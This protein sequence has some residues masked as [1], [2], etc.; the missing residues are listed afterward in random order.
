MIFIYLLMLLVFLAPVSAFADTDAVC[1]RVY[2]VVKGADTLYQRY[3]GNVDLST[4]NY[5]ITELHV[6]QHGTNENAEVYMNSMMSAVIDSGKNDTIAAIGP[7]FTRAYMQGM[8]FVN[9]R[10]EPVGGTLDLNGAD[11]D[12]LYYGSGW[13]SGDESFTG[14]SEGWVIRPFRASSFEAMDSLLALAFTKYPNLKVMKLLGHS[15]G[16]QFMTRYAMA[17]N[18]PYGFP[19]Q[20]IFIMTTNPSSSAYFDSLRPVSPLAHPITFETVDSVAC[21]GANDWAYA[22]VDLDENGICDDC[23]NYMRTKNPPE[24]REKF[25]KHIHIRGIA[26]DDNDPLSSD[27]DVTCQ[28][29][30]QGEQRLARAEGFVEHVINYFGWEKWVRSYEP[31]YFAGCGHSFSCAWKSTCGR[32]F[33]YGQ[34]AASCADIHPLNSTFDVDLSGW[35]TTGTGNFTRTT[36]RRVKGAGAAMLK[37]VMENL[38]ITSEVFSVSGVHTISWGWWLSS[39]MDAEDTISLQLQIDGGAWTEIDRL[40]GNVSQENTWLFNGLSV[41][42]T[43]SLRLRFVGN[44]NRT[45]EYAVIDEIKILRRHGVN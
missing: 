36:N 38:T 7:Q 16:G 18:V 11:S 24:L 28:G 2:P 33:L 5:N 4:V 26:L 34:N 41:K 15:A 32:Y 30:S 29:M 45:N 12:N 39:T 31:M 23:N 14:S 1:N 20:N 19:Y 35:T 8:P 6:Y 27:L 3:C 43:A 25:R 37:G 9:E 40:Q 42:P 13:R 17:M 21:P 10:D 22:M 44:A